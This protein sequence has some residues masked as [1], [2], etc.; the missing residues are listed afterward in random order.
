L[1]TDLPRIGVKHFGLRVSSITDA[2]NFIEERGLGTNIEIR[3]GK[4][5]V[6][7]FFIKDPSGILL[8]F[9]ED[10]RSL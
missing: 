5:G 3:E 4:T 10:N 2:K 6:T 8:E 7:Y 9:V 1:A